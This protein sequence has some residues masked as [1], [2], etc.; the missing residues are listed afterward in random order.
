MESMTGYGHSSVESKASLLE[1]AVKA[2]NGRYFEVRVHS[3]RIFSPY[4]KDIKTMVRKSIS[5]GSVDVFVQRR[6]YGLG[7]SPVFNKGLAKK[8]TVGFS[9]L[10]KQVGLTS[11][12]DPSLLLSVPELFSIEEKK[13]SLIEKKQLLEAL[14]QACQICRQQRQQEGRGLK[15]DLTKQLSRLKKITNQLNKLRR[16]ANSEAKK[17]WMKKYREILG[18]NTESTARALQEVGLLIERSDI[19]EELVRLESHIEGAKELLNSGLSVGKRLDFYAQEFL[20]EI[21][22]V[23]SK[24]ASAPMTRA[25]VEGKDIVE[26]FREQVQNVQ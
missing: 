12:L 26:K 19:H 23:G 10:L 9:D 22:T 11:E 18:D 1:V 13:S 21:N 4:E 24:C 7:E 3:P 16:A 5:R 6:S 2:V 25:V 14:D 15:K 8:W 20:R 17:K